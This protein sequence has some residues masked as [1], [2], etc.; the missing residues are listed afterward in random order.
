MDSFVV[1]AAKASSICA[2]DTSSA[3][4]LLALVAKIDEGKTRRS[5]SEGR[6]KGEVGGRSEGE[7]ESEVGGKSEGEVEDKVEGEGEGEVGGKS[8]GEV[9]GMGRWQEAISHPSSSRVW[10]SWGTARHPA[11]RAAAL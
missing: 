8:E 5:T 4:A 1:A 10:G 9:A 6:V 3:L 11:E 2:I 7:V